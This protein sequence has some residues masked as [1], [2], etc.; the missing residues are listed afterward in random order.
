VEGAV[1]V[2][3]LAHH[4]VAKRLDDDAAVRVDLLVERLEEIV[5][6]RERLRVAELLVDRGALA[7]VGEENCAL[8]AGLANVPLPWVLLRGQIDIKP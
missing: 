2:A 6:Q 7:D 4:A 1:G 5:D 8:L 3:E